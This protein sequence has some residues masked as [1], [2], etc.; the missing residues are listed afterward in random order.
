MNTIDSTNSLLSLAIKPLFREFVLIFCMY[1]IIYIIVYD[2]CVPIANSF[3]FFL[4][5]WQ[6][7]IHVCTAHLF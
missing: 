3:F 6:L 5:S 7:N 2:L 1:F 4:S